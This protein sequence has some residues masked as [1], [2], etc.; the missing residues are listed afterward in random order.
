MIKNLPKT[1]EKMFGDIVE[2]SKRTS[3]ERSRKR[4]SKKL[5]NPR[6][7]QIHFHTLRH[8][9]ATMLYNQTK[10]LL[11]VKE[12]LG[13]RNINSTLKHVQLEQV[14]FDGDVDSFTCRVAK[15]PGEI[16]Q[17]IEAGF[18]CV[19]KNDG[20]VYFRKRK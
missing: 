20:L 7:L 5:D 10:D 8:W 11:Y 4:L 16:K 2:N 1:S 19:T 13:H 3:F 12:F 14:L 9:K 18:D 6:L 15:T 17:F